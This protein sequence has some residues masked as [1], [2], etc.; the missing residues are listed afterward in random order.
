[1]PSGDGAQRLNPS[2]T[3][4]RVQISLIRRFNSPIGSQKVPVCLGGELGL[5]SFWLKWCLQDDFAD[6]QQSEAANL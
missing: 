4:I 3:L 2:L 6:V 1:M 5:L